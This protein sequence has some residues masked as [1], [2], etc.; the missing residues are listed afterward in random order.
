MKL[1]S[2][3]PKEFAIFK[4]AQRRCEPGYDANYA[5]R[6]IEF[7]FQSFKQFFA[8]VGPRPEGTYPSGKSRYS[9][10]RINNNGHYEPGNVRWADWSDQNSNKRP[11][12]KSNPALITNTSFPS[13]HT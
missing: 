8:E 11:R 1:E 5:N 7:R 3:H 9:I 12:K 2:K 10:E 4:L 13:Q 6:G